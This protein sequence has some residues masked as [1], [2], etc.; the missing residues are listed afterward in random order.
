MNIVVHVQPT[1]DAVQYSAHTAA[2][3]RRVIATQQCIMDVDDDQDTLAERPVKRQ[4]RFTFQR[5]A[6]RVAE[7][8]ARHL[9]Y[10]GT[11]SLMRVSRRS[12]AATKV[13]INSTLARLHAAND[14]TYGTQ[15]GNASTTA[16]Q[17]QCVWESKQG[18]E[19]TPSGID[20]LLSGK[21]TILVHPYSV[22]HA[23]LQSFN[24][25]SL[26]FHAGTNWR[27]AGVEQHSSMAGGCKHPQPFSA[28]TAA[29]AASP[30]RC[31]HG[32]FK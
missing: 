2:I 7:V 15:N 13:A 29:A 14:T 8:L 19:R 28:I 22:S 32:L 16:G 6:Q 11:V 24:S 9:L 20:L 5:F 30:G 17:H 10:L 26:T 23:K 31:C 4:K 21:L 1:A 3:A 27:V 12:Y 25:A 18:Q